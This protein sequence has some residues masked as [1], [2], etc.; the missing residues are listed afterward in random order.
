MQLV[1]LSVNV[2]I[3]VSCVGLPQY[4]TESDEED[5]IPETQ[6]FRE[7]PERAKHDLACEATQAYGC[8]KF[9]ILDFKALLMI[10]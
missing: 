6:D 8:G 9:S 1:I 2:Y 4:F 3:S 5:A 7:S 10:N